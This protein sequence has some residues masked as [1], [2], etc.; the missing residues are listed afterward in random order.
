MYQKCVIKD[1]TCLNM[2]IFCFWHQCFNRKCSG[3]VRDLELGILE[4]IR[5]C[6]DLQIE[7]SSQTQQ[8][9]GI[10]SICLC[11]SCIT[12]Y[13]GQW[14]WDNILCVYLVFL[15]LS[16]VHLNV[17]LLGNFSNWKK[18]NKKYFYLQ[19]IQIQMTSWWRPNCN[20]LLVAFVVDMLCNRLISGMFT[21][22]TNTHHRVFCILTV[23]WN[24]QF[25]SLS[26]YSD[27]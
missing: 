2:S 18:S 22:W 14:C 8:F 7:I 4:F 27:R 11:R 24:M 5:I 3:Q 16:C 17:Y 15:C 10:L 23:L 21:S 26:S 1:S 19:I 6:S 25:H 13:I 9:F 12:G 20:N